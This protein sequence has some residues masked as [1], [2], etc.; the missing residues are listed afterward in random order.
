MIWRAWGAVD[1]K[2]TRKASATVY[3]SQAEA[4]EVLVFNGEKMK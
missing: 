1:I 2:Y 4:L 3:H